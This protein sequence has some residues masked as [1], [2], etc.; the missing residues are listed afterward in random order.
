MS[1]KL[2]SASSAYLNFEFIK[3]KNYVTDW[4]NSKNLR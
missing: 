1:A 4:Q 2:K 3:K